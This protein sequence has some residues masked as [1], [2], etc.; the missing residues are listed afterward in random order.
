M[1]GRFNS[2]SKER[3]EEEVMVK[4]VHGRA[5]ER[6]AIARHSGGGVLRGEHL[7]RVLKTRAKKYSRI[8][9]SILIPPRRCSY[10]I[11]ITQGNLLK[12]NKHD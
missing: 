1:G 4:A 6:M 7:T 11:K 5:K 9:D 3:L 2:Q 10:R 12:H 8:E